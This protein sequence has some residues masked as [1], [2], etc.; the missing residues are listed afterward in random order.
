MQ[1]GVRTVWTAAQMLY[2]EEA[3]QGIELDNSVIRQ[4]IVPLA[5]GAKVR[6]TLSN[7][8]GKSP[9]ELTAVRIADSL[10]NGK[11]DIDSEKIITFSGKERVVIPA[12]GCICSDIIEYETSPCVPAVVT[13]STGYTPA[14]ITGHEVALNN[15]YIK[16]GGSVSDADMNGASVEQKSFIISSVETDS[17]CEIVVCV[18]DSTTDGVGASDYKNTWPYIL[19]S[20]LSKTNTGLIAV[21]QGIGGNKLNGISIG[22]SARLRFERDVLHLDGVKYVIVFEGINDI[23]GRRSDIPDFDTGETADGTISGGII[24]TLKEMTDKAHKHGIKLICGTILPCGAHEYCTDAQE[25]MRKRINSWILQNKD[26]DGVIDFDRIISDPDNIRFM[27][28][29]YD[30]G[31]GLHP[32]DDGYKAMAEGIDIK[33]FSSDRD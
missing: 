17:E 30:C 14:E 25:A 18:G 31:D 33:L 5:G 24:E 11:I 23:G 28:K 29:E 27:K 6:F 20:R 22:D 15:V 4:E 21:N 8:Y 26:F 9:I 2:F 32:S 19:N 3:A 12:G 13:M 16:R 10:G 7:E 1:I